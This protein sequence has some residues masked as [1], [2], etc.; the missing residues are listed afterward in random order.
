MVGRT[1]LYR[2]C[3]YVIKTRLGN[4]MD[5]SSQSNVKQHRIH[6]SMRVN[7]DQFDINIRLDILPLRN[8]SR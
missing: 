3:R 4:I 5:E 2:E 6:N 1:K 8:Q 7:S